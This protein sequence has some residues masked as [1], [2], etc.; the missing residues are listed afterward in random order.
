MLSFSGVKTQTYSMP[1]FDPHQVDASLPL[2]D[3]PDTK[4]PEHKLEVSK[5]SYFCFLSWP[6]LR[7]GWILIFTYEY[8]ST[9]VILYVS[10]MTLWEY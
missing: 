6:F 1:L 7:W 3:I 4:V 5:E 10:H 2:Y 9:G 8:V